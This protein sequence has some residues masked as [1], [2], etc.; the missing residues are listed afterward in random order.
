MQINFLPAGKTPDENARGNLFTELCSMQLKEYFAGDRRFFSFPYKLSGTEFQ[1]EVWKEIAK[2]PYGET[3]SYK[4]LAERIHK[5]QAVRA[6]AS[7]ANENKLLFCV[8]CH[9][10]IGSDGSLTGFSAG[11][12]VKQQLLDLEKEPEVYTIL[13]FAEVQKKRGKTPTNRITGRFIYDTTD[14]LFETEPGDVLAAH[15]THIF[16]VHFDFDGCSGFTLEADAFMVDAYEPVN[17]LTQE[18]VI[19][20]YNASDT[21]VT[22]AILSKGENKLHYD[23]NDMN[24]TNVYKMSV[25]STKPLRNLRLSKLNVPDNYFR[26]KGQAKFYTPYGCTLDESDY[27]LTLSLNGKAQLESFVFPDSSNYAYNMKMPIR[28]TIFVV[29]KNMSTA[30]KMRLYYKT[31][32]NSEYCEENSVEIPISR[33]PEYKAYYF[34]LSAI[35]FLPNLITFLIR[36][37]AV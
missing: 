25:F 7:A 18:V 23:I 36:Q 6:V 13:N 5:P 21:F 28:N 11:L 34:N 12:L 26:Y 2:I 37:I 16:P 14:I 22:K 17:I 30:S 19:T 8:P 10:V 27:T 35:Q 33:A 9:R 15:K 3:I 4:E 24:F 31:T 20:F 1:N 29:I 32:V